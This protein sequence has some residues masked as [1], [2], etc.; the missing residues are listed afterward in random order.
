[1]TR[2]HSKYRRDYRTASLTQGYRSKY[3]ES[4]QPRVPLKRGYHLCEKCRN[5]LYQIPHRPHTFLSL[6]HRSQ[7]YREISRSAEKWEL[8]FPLRGMVDHREEGVNRIWA[9][10]QGTILHRSHQCST[11]F[12]RTYSY[13]IFSVRCRIPLHLHSFAYRLYLWI[14]TCIWDISLMSTYTYPLIWLWGTL[15]KWFL[16]RACLSPHD[17]YS[18]RHRSILS[19]S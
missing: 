2:P 17:S 15:W 18:P 4:K 11:H 12:C 1:M 14:Y 10:I 16:D 5:H 6:Y 13:R 9:Y 3:D 8:P 19:Q 7:A